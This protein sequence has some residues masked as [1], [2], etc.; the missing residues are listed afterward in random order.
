M[1]IHIQ[2]NVYKIFDIEQKHPTK[3]LRET[4]LQS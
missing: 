1:N 3:H 4:F 2:Q